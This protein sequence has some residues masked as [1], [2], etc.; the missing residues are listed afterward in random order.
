MEENSDR[1][2][3]SGRETVRRDP[4]RRR[5]VSDLVNQ[6]VT[7]ANDN[8]KITVTPLERD[9]Y[10]GEQVKWICQE[11]AWEI[12]FD[13]V[14]SQTPFDGDVFGPGLIP[15]ALDPDTNPNLPPDE[16]PGELSGPV[17]ED[18][19]PG[20]YFYTVQVGAFGPLSARIRI[21]GGPRP[22]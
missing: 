20:E 13:Q 9:L 22:R 4:T 8:G 1:T 11:L 5:P 12:R 16:I 21:I 3:T 17:R 6:P 15:L 10:D 19:L 18:T 14:G 2:T 7:I